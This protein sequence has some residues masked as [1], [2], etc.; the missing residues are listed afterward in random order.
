MVEEEE[1]AMGRM[2]GET[3][4]ER[5]IGGGVEVDSSRH[6]IDPTAKS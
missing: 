1:E 2:E 3:D 6:T 5:V 4:V